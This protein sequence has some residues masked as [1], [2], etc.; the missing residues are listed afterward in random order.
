MPRN[1]ADANELAVIRR[2]ASDS[3]HVRITKTAEYDLLANRLTKEDVCDEIVA[4]IDK[5]ERVKKV[6]LR[7]QHAGQ[8]AFEMKPRISGSLFY[9]KVTL[10]E[11]G[12]P[13]EFMLIISAHL[14]H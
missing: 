14:D 10:C 3:R 1:S 5:G 12:D 9:F 13:G 2:L 4:W 7:G 11:L 8:A 6:T